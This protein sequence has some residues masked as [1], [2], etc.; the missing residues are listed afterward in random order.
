MK[1][2]MIPYVILIWI[3]VKTGVMPWNLKTQFWSTATGTLILFL[4]FSASRFWS[5]VDMT[6]SSTIRAPH[7]VVSA[8]FQQEVDQIFVTHNQFVKKDELLYTLVDE[9][10]AS[11]VDAIDAQIE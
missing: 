2:I 10:T 11:G 1:E 3:L 6:N 9:S 4:L 8:L 7:A 5:P